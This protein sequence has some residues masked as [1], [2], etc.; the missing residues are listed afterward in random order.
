LGAPGQD[1][2]KLVS[3]NNISY[4]V[5]TQDEVLLDILRTKGVC[6]LLR[7]A[8]GVLLLENPSKAS[9]Q[10]AQYQERS[11]YSAQPQERNLAQSLK[12]EERQ[13]RQQTGSVTGHRVKHKAQGPN[14]LSCKRK[15]APE[16]EPRKRRRTRKGNK[17]GE[18][19]SA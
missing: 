2:V 10:N 17:G 16:T 5:A 3:S 19:A 13:Q 18:S 8:R 6:P 7:L 4:L 12:E 1:I 15:S 9:Q 11:K 14:P